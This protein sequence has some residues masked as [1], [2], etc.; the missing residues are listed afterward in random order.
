MALA[1]EKPHVNGAN[2]ASTHWGL[3]GACEASGAVVRL[4]VLQDGPQTV[5]GGAG[6]PQSRRTGLTERRD[7]GLPRPAG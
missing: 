4:R 7:A 2:W 6:G 5:T 3:L 1:V